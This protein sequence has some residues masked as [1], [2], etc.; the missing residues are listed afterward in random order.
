MP[1]GG[2][3]AAASRACI[4]RHTHVGTH[5]LCAPALRRKSQCARPQVGEG[6]FSRLIT[7]KGSQAGLR[8]VL[9]V[10]HYDV[11]PVTPGTEAGWRHPPF[12][13]KVAD[14]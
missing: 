6:G 9:F 4:Y 8:P 13:A 10:S 14:G 5:L 7:W 2:P 11:V 3:H 1:G 12:E